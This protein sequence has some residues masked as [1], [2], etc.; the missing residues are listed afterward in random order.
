[1]YS[2][3]LDRDVEITVFSSGRNDVA[4][5]LILMHD[6]QNLFFNT[7][8]TYGTSW[9]LLDILPKEDFPDCVL[10]GMTCGKDALRMDEYGPFVFDD[11]AQL[12]TGYREPIGGR[13]DAHLAFVYRELIPL[14]RK[15]FR[16]RD[17]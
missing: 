15:E 12:Q 10:I 11:Y 9:G 7:L 5:P 8:A 3:N 2:E 6:G 14:I 1:M 16:C 4:R 17:K 13:G